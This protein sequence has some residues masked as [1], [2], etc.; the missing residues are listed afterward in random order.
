M[1]LST[2]FIVILVAILCGSSAVTAA[3]LID[4][5]G[6]ILYVTSGGSGNCT[7]WAD[8]PPEVVPLTKLDPQSMN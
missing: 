3:P 6:K 8:Q 2:L 5:G 7:S 4:T 1:K